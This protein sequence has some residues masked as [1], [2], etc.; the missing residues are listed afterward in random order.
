MLN[1]ATHK[2]MARRLA[3]PCSP[4]ARRWLKRSLQLAFV[5]VAVFLPAAHCQ[6]GGVYQVTNI[7]SDGYVPAAN[8][9]P[10]FI[11]PW[12]VSGGKSLWI[13]TAVTG[14]SYVVPIVTP[15]PPA[16]PIAF[17]AVVPPAP[18]IT[19]PGQP[20]GTIQNTTTGFILSNGAKASFLF[21]TLDG[22]ISGWN[23]LT[24]AGGNNSLI[25]VN[26][27]AKNAVYTDMALVTNA[28]GSFALVTN[29]GA[30][31]SVEAYNTSFQLTPLAG[32]FTDPNTPAGYAPYGIHVIGSQVFVTYM[33]RTVPP[34]SAYQEV[35]GTNTGFVSVFDVNGNFVS[36]A[37]TG[38]LLNAPWGVAI[39]PAGF[40]IYAG[41]LLVGNFGDGLI[42]AYN[43]TTYAYLGTLADAN[44]NAISY[45]GL[46]ELFANANGNASAL[47]FVAGLANETHGL[48][49]SIANVTTATSAPTFNLS[50]I[51]A[52]ATVKVGGATTVTLGLA[53][54]NSFTGTVAFSCSGLPLGATCNFAPSPLLTL[55][56]N[57]PSIETVSIVTAKSVGMQRKQELGRWKG[58]G[59]ALAV[60]LPFWSHALGR[61]RSKLFRLRIAAMLGFVFVSLGMMAGCSNTYTPAVTPTG[62]STVTITA[63]SGSVTRTT[64][65][66]L[67]VQ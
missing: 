16:S 41:D 27:N 44:G 1:R 59:I 7:L 30:G 26:N 42:T 61:R 53:P 13:D 58:S 65:V 28:S 57:A 34:T 52:S 62:S 46:W 24:S 37:I 38:G 29:F 18:G 63:T 50:N 66:A 54:I 51:N 56:P 31:A 55:V 33:L 32:S 40:G 36:R 60:L 49:G 12:G 5:A 14:Y 64:T 35:L 3:G 45:P 17:K 39:A 10:N 47:Y 2:Q 21:A 43:P 15:A 6:T 67:T 48:F 11:D 25:M 4:V 20:T 22:T 23:S 8:T 9:D 19:G